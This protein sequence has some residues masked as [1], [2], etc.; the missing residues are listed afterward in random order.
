VKVCLLRMKETYT[1][2]F[3]RTESLV[4]C[5]VLI[6]FYYFNYVCMPVLG[7]GPVNT[8]ACALRDQKK[9]LD[10]LELSHTQL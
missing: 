3:Q 4:L 5:I 1:H 10:H 7:N 8:N 2:T 6:I 9:A